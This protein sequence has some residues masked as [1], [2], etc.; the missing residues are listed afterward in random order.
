MTTKRKKKSINVKI[1]LQLSLTKNQL[2]ILEYTKEKLDDVQEVKFIH[3]DIHGNLKVVP[4][5]SPVQCKSV[6]DFQC[7]SDIGRLLLQLSSGDEDYE[8]LYDD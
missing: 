6:F 7:E 5:P 4:N 8:N 1:N 3:A 2:Q